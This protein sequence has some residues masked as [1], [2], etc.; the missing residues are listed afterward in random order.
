MGVQRLCGWIKGDSS[1]K[2]EIY[3]F[4]HPAYFNIFSVVFNRTKKNKNSSWFV[5]SKKL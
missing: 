2:T 4:N 5:T 3:L 1:Y